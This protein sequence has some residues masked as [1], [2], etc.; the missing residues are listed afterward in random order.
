LPVIE[1]IGI[2]IGTGP[3][4]SFIGAALLMIA[5]IIRTTSQRVIPAMGGIA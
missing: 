1:E 3:D 4:Y 5:L 2:N